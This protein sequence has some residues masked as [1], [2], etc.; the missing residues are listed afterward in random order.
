MWGPT[1]THTSAEHDVHCTILP[2][3]FLFWWHIHPVD[4]HVRIHSKCGVSHAIACKLR[5]PFHS[6][7]QLI[8]FSHLDFVVSKSFACVC[9]CV[10][11]SSRV[12]ANL[13]VCMISKMNLTELSLC[14]ALHSF[15]FSFFFLN[16]ETTTQ[17]NARNSSCL[18]VCFTV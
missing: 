10:C 16:R 17:T 15:F 6:R 11:V 9:L 12:C 2:S 5:E 7:L 13:I 4:P 3:S 8:K 18:K 14:A 1:Q